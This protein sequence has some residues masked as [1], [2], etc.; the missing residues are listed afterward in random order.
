MIDLSNYAANDDVK[1]LHSPIASLNAMVAD[2]PDCTKYKDP[3]VAFGK[4]VFSPAI[5]GGLPSDALYPGVNLN[6]EPLNCG[7]TIVGATIDDAETGPPNTLVSVV[8]ASNST[9]S[10]IYK[11]IAF[12]LLFRF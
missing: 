2:E 6:S 11:D 3:V 9:C 8:N 1:Y 10:F 5:V 7:V 4:I 12:L